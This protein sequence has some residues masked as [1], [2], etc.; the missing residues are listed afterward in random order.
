MFLPIRT[1][2][3]LRRKPV[4]NIA[5]IVI[6]VAV[7]AVLSGPQAQHLRDIAEGF[8]LDPHN[9]K[10]Y[11]FI[12]SLFLHADWMHLLSNMLF[13]YIFG[14]AVE[15]RLGKVGYVGFYLAGGVM[16]CLGHCMTSD[17]RLLGASGAVSAVSGGFLVLFPMTHV[18]IL[19]WFFF[20]GFF[21]IPSMY[22]ILFYFAKDVLYHFADV[23][24]VAYMAHIAGTVFGFVVCTLLLRSRVLPREPYDMIS[25]WQHWRRRQQFKALA[26][27]PGFQPWESTQ[28]GAPPK[29]G[30]NSDEPP[31]KP[32]DPAVF[33]KRSEISRAMAAH[34]L[35]R[36]C[37]LYAE[38][39]D[40]DGEQ[41]L[42][43]TNQLNLANHFAKREHYSLAARA[44]ELLINTYRQLP[45]RDRIQLMLALIY[46]RY[47]ERGQRARE[48]LT[49]AV[50]RLRDAED[51]AMAAALQSELER[52]GT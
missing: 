41:V 46:V 44:Y 13:L 49:D 33:Q 27:T 50:P 14:N 40:T 17:S 18:T 30:R 11:Q 28:S 29:Q 52:M 15:D 35:D 43:Q 37:E 38:L 31:G 7:H 10:W 12:T 45:D 39:L 2:Q 4:I 48:L 1:D 25:M 23:G 8:V 16:A 21:Q 34:N 51:K 9:T 19:F 47:L 24:R 3:P 42:S 20:I 22:F 36:A 6:T 26:Q 5:I 32:M